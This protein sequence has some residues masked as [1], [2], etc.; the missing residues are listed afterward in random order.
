MLRVGRILKNVAIHSLEKI[1]SPALSGTPAT[2]AG[3]RLPVNGGGDNKMG[4]VFS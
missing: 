2:S 1:P 3:R 4:Q